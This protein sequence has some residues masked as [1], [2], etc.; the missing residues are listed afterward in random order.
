MSDAS[1]SLHEPVELL[2]TETLEAQRGIVT[3][4]EELEAIDWYEQRIDATQD[5]QLKTLLAHNRDEEKEHAMMALEWLRR[6]DPALDA[7]MRTYLFTEG[8]IVVQE[9]SSEGDAPAEPPSEPP[10]DTTLGIG[11]LRTEV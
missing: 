8:D 3:L 2:T 7:Q 9:Q 6:R 4:I 5:P 10:A 1:T 11:S